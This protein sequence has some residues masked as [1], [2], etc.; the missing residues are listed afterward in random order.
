MEMEDK[1][2]H[3]SNCEEATKGRYLDKA[4]SC[5]ALLPKALDTVRHDRYNHSYS[6]FERIRYELIM[7]QHS[8][9]SSSHPI[10]LILHLPFL[11]KNLTDQLVH[12][13]RVLTTS[14]ATRSLPLHRHLSCVMTIY[15]FPKSLCFNLSAKPSG[16]LFF[17]SP[18]S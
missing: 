17:T 13:A 12:F 1:D 9:I 3:K 18:F 8:L 14:T 11:S 16:C 2:K 5:S 4:Q 6:S 7:Q 15:F 10:H